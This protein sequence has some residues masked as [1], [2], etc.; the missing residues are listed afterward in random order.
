MDVRED[1]EWQG[2]HVEGALH[3]PYHALAA[4]IPEVLR[5]ADRP[6]ALACSAG[7]RSSI[8]ASLLQRAGIDEVVHVAD[9]GIAD[10]PQFGVALVTES[11]AAP[12]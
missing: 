2:G 7:N 10:L 6:L 8:A 11:A 4:G 1:E 9:G 5:A 12:A 3:V